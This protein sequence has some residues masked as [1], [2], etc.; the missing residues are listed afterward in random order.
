MVFGYV[1]LSRN[2][3]SKSS[4]TVRSKPS[5]VGLHVYGREDK[6]VPINVRETVAS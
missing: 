6:T 1:N 4:A 2:P 3:I 5:N